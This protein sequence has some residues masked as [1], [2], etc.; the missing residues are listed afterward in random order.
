MEKPTD[1]KVVIEKENIIEMPSLF[2][3]VQYCFTTYYVMNIAYPSQVNPLM[4]FLE[5]ELFGLKPSSKIPI[6]VTVLRDNLLK[7]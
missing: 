7:C 1:F 5:T 3:A 2:V 4:L 6:S